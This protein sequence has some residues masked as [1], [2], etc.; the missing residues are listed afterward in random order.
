VSGTLGDARLALEAL[1]RNLSLSPA[2]LQAAALRLHRPEPRVALG[3]A[4]RGIA[5]AAID[6]SD[7]LLGDLGHLLE[8]SSL[9]AVIDADAL[10]FGETLASQPLAIRRELALNGGD[11]YEL[12]FTAAPA[13]RDRVQAAARQS[14]VAVTRIG[15]ITADPSLRVTDA[16]GDAVAVTSRSFDHFG[17]P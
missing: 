3:L 12:C 4:L 15:Y 16:G 14:G 6:L 7:G 11:D 17:N 2:A 9:G 13:L 5:S 10:P 1:Q 8:R